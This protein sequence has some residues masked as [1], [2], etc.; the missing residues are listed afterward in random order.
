MRR[1]VLA[2]GCAGALAL[3]GCHRVPEPVQAPFY[4]R[5]L[6][7]PSVGAEPYHWS[8]L[9]GRVVLVAFFA[10]WSFP[11]LAELP[12]LEAL[13]KKYGPQGFQVVLVGLEVEGARI[14]EPFAQQ[15]APPFPVLVSDERMQKG[16]S[17]FGLI[18]ALPTTVLLDRRGD[19]AGAW[20]GVAP[21]GAMAQAVE[22]LLAR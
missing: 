17:S 22:T 6:N 14:L 3:A 20:Q 12:T 10:T 7:L 2:L 21:H 5:E 16:G 9:T 18:P 1:A 13:Q 19:V 8:Q 11:A 15:F 4:L